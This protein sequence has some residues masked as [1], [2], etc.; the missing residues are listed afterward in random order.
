MKPSAK[1]EI[2]SHNL[3]LQPAEASLLRF[4][5]VIISGEIQKP[6]KVNRLPDFVK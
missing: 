6:D 5:E 2:T 4:F 1:P 3:P